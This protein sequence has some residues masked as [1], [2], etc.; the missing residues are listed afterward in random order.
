M[1]MQ[2]GVYR[3]VSGLLTKILINLQI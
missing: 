2:D 3:P 1:A